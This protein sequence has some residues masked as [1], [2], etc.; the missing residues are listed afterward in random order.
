VYNILI[1]FGISLKLVRL[2]EV[3]LTIQ[4]WL[5]FY[6]MMPTSILGIDQV[7]GV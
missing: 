4:S 2:I 6:C 7:Y 5:Q 3:C 1:G